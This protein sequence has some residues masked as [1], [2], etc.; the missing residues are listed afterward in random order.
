MK[1]ANLVLLGAILSVSSS[2][3]AI[4]LLFPVNFPKFS[5][6]D[7]TINVNGQDTD[8]TV[9]MV[10]DEKGK[11]QCLPGDCTVGGTEVAW[12]ATFNY[13]GPAGKATL[14]L[15]ARLSLAEMDG[16]PPRNKVIT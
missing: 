15:Y 1:I 10:P 16:A 13:N 11:Y 12:I 2:V 7:A 6:F 14:T 8:V 9:R 4:D 3:S 5:G